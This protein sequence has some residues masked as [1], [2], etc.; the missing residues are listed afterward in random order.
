LFNYATKYHKFLVQEVCGSAVDHSL[1]TLRS[2]ATLSS[3]NVK[4]GVNMRLAGKTAWVLA[5][6]AAWLLVPGF[7]RGSNSTPLRFLDPI[8]SRG[9]SDGGA[10]LAYKP[11]ATT[12]RVRDTRG[13]RFADAAVDAG[14]GPVAGGAGTFLLSCATSPATYLLATSDG[15]VTAGPTAGSFVT[16]L[17]I[18]RDWI[19]GLDCQGHCGPIYLSRRTGETRRVSRR[20]DLDTTDLRLYDPRHHTIGLSGPP[21]RRY[22]YLRPPGTKAHRV[23][24][25]RCSPRCDQP[26]AISGHAVW[27]SGAKVHSYAY[28]TGRRCAWAA[29]VAR[30]DNP[31]TAVALFPTRPKLAFAVSP[32]SGAGRIYTARWC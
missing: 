26:R 6:L 17:D 5:T 29:P 28:S 10:F 4:S 2:H 27:L 31:Y 9:V 23:R 32:R 11:A 21:S 25:S 24:L 13:A 8:A 7:A 16:W 15:S 22:L 3:V 1:G 30:G 18:G 12:L 19:G 20:R 14:C